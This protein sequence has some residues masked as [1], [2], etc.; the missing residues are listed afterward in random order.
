MSA[1]IRFIIYQKN[2]IITQRKVPRG[3]TDELLHLFIDSFST[4]WCSCWDFLLFSSLFDI[5]RLAAEV[6]MSV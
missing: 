1:Y 2:F 3:K 4:C 6:K 5:L